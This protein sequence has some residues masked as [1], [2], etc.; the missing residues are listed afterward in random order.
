MFQA[1]VA[2]EHAAIQFEF[3]GIL[4]LCMRTAVTAVRV[5]SSHISLRGR[6]VVHNR[7]RPCRVRACW[8]WLARRTAATTSPLSWCE[9]RSISKAIQQ[10]LVL[11]MAQYHML[12]QHCAV[13]QSIFTIA[14]AFILSACACVEVCSFKVLWVRRAMIHQP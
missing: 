14:N 8:V 4:D 10:V 3:P 7:Q 1:P 2:Q 5:P 13:T 11:S 12:L 6:A 9:P